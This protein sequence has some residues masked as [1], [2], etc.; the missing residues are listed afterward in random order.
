ML[1]S[2]DDFGRPYTDVSF[3]ISVRDPETVRSRLS[4][5]QTQIGIK[6]RVGGRA[7]GHWWVMGEREGRAHNRPL[8]GGM[9]GRR[10]RPS[11]RSH[12]ARTQ[13]RMAS[14]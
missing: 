12:H 11:H 10:C 2:Q 6:N 9:Q 14:R 3:V 8:S 13:R 5:E 1:P 4:A 7:G